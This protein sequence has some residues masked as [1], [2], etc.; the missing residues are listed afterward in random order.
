[1]P[2]DA[3]GPRD[4]DAK[5]ARIMTMRKSK[6]LE[7]ETVFVIGLEGQAGRVV[8]WYPAEMTL[9]DSQEAPQTQVGST[10]RR[11]VPVT[12]GAHE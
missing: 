7:A 5:L 6:G 1:M 4:G 3:Y 9:Y 8:V 10:G 12:L 2:T 11:R